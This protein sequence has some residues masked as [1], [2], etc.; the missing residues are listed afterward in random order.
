MH[1]Q[2]LSC[3]RLSA[4]LWTVVHQAPLPIRF[5][6]QEYWSG[7]PYPSPEDLPVP[8]IKP[9]SLASPA[10]AGGYFTSVPPGKQPHI[11]VYH[12]IIYCQLRISTVKKNKAE[13]RDR[14]NG[15]WERGYFP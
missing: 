14:D 6:Q 15:R 7:L 10:S 9:A 2:S 1:A 4:T 8:G 3:V 12:K 11:I 13:E 5:F